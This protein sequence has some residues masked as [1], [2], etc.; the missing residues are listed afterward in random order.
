[1]SKLYEET[2]WRDLEGKWNNEP[3]HLSID[4]GEFHL[5]VSRNHSGTLN[6]YVGV[7]VDNPLFQKGIDHSYLDFINVHG[8][9]TFSGSGFISHEFKN[10]H[11]YFGFDTA[12]GGDLVPSIVAMRGMTEKF[13]NPLFALLPSPISLKEEYRDLNYVT[14]NVNSLYEQL[15]SISKDIGKKETS[16]IKMYRKL[17]R[18]KNKYKQWM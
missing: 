18:L 9:L 2:N 8:G 13:S 15:M 10:T 1:V 12:H 16:H 11:W 17:R 5:V 6:G 7:R 14:D 4:N 3:D